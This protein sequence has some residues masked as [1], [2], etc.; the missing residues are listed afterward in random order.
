ML[1]ISGVVDIMVYENEPKTLLIGQLGVLGGCSAWLIIA[2]LFNM[3]VSTTQSVVGATI[4]FSVCLK[5]L[6][7]IRWMEIVKI[8]GSWFASPL[9]SGFIS[10]ILYLIVDHSVLRKPQP[11]VYGLKVLP[12][13]YFVCIA[14]VT[15]SVSYQGSKGEIL[16]KAKTIA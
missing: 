13:F 8:I 6:D 7:G 16:K 4:G 15:F 5:G 11:L 14:F 10:T 12:F 1:F 2:T 9:L 3:P